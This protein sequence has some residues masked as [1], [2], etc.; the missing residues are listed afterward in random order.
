QECTDPHLA[1]K[2]AFL[3]QV[4]DA[5]FGLHRGSEAQ[6]GQLSPVGEKDRHDHPYRGGLAGAI[7][8]DESVKSVFGDDEIQ[9]FHSGGSAE[10]L[11]HTLEDDCVA[12]C[13]SSFHWTLRTTQN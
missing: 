4:T 13:G 8:S 2:S 11:G 1:V 5:V 7:R 6:Y 3:R 10:G 12:H 9:I